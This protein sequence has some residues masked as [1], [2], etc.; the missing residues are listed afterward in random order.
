M[1]KDENESV[2]IALRN[3][4][5]PRL[6]ERDSNVLATLLKDLW[7]DVNISMMS[8]GIK[9]NISSFFIPLHVVVKLV[10]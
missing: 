6:P 5:M 10:H 1:L 9:S 7:P 4:F 8:G 3:T 2:V